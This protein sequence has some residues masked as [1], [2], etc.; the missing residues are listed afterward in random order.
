MFSNDR[1]EAL[2]YTLSCLEDMKPFRDS[3][4]ILVVDGKLKHKVKHFE[5]CEV[6]RRGRF[7]WADM[8][9]RGV[10]KAIHET[11]V[12][13]DSDRLLP[14]NFLDLVLENT[15]ENTFVF[16]S[17]HFLMLEKWPVQKCKS[18]LERF[19][20]EKSILTS[21]EFIG[22]LGFDVR[23]IHPLIGPGKNVMSGSVAF[24]KSTYL[25]LGGV[26]PWYCGHGAYADTDFHRIAAEAGCKFV[27]LKIPELHFPHEKLGPHPL[28][29]TKLHQLAF[30]N[31]MHYL[32]K[33]N[34]S[35]EIARKI[36]YNLNIPFKE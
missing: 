34:L 4:K 19:P 35:F 36:S 17:Y 18:F 16:T 24:K 11:I 7:C 28:S 3:Q 14:H 12:Y 21:P 6:L 30:V 10:H 15:Q 26:D 22:Q 29:K 2:E 13:L 25:R 9:N 1:K 31:L 8:W 20:S 23:H 32:K 5:I 33:W 27:D